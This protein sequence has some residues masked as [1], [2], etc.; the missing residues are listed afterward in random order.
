MRTGRH[1]TD[2]LLIEPVW[3]RN[4]APQ[5]DPKHILGT[6]NRT[7]LESKLDTRY[8]AFRRCLPF[9]R[10]SL[11]SKLQS[12]T[13]LNSSQ[14]ALLIEPVW[15]RNIL[16]VRYS[17]EV[18]VILLIEP[19]WNRNRNTPPHHALPMRLLLI[20][21]VWNRNMTSLATALE[22]LDTGF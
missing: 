20:E 19:V 4:I 1:F 3:N 22:T 14:N 13:L 21:P 8:L 17:N 9:N 18:D 5:I 10:T 12:V 16:S 11:E 7:S 15:N 6:F 2:L